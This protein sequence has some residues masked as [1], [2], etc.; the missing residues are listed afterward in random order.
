[1]KI[2]FPQHPSILDIVEDRLFFNNPIDI[3]KVTSME[4]QDC[5][6]VFG[7]KRIIPTI[8]QFVSNTQRDAQWKILL[9]DS[10]NLTEGN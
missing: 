7:Y 5:K 4:K 10:T 8:W 2:I 3:D 9:S 1:M 6:I